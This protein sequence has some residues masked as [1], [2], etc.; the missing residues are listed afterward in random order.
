MSG[1]VSTRWYFPD[2]LSDTAV[3]A[4][5]LAARG[6]W[7]DL[8]CIAAA[9]KGKDHGFVLIGGKV[10]S[11]DQIAKLVGSTAEEVK[12]LLAELEKNEVFSRDRR[13]AIYSR[14]MVRAEKNRTNGRL[15][16]NPKLLKNNEIQEPVEP[17]PKPHIPEPEPNLFPEAGASGSAVMQNPP[18]DL[19]ADYY[20]RFKEICGANSGGMATRLLR[21]KGGNLSL[22]RAAIETAATRAD[23]REYIGAMLRNGGG[24]GAKDR[25][26]DGKSLGGFGGIAASIRQR[27]RDAAMEASDAG[28]DADL[29]EWGRR[30]PHA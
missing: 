21:A 26:D 3:R 9:N 15:G 8:L 1:T 24:F 12:T 14:R 6:L 19:E 29:D 5:S 22:A 10:P 13:K 23:A 7:M 4:S 2:W 30:R 11:E 27:Q 25:R 28:A 20:H 16:G 18:R 17:H